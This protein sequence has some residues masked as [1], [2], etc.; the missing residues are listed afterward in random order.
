MTADDVLGTVEVPLEDLMTK[1]ETLNRSTPH[2]DRFTDVGGSPWPGSVRWS[3]GY[4]AKTGLEAAKPHDAEEVKK[5]VDKQAEEKLKEAQGRGQGEDD[6]GELR[7]QKAEDLKE[8][9]EEIIAGARPSTEWPSGVLSI[10]IE[11]ITGLEVDKIR[12]SGVRE[13]GEDEERDDLPSAYCTVIIDH[14]R[15]YKTRTKLK[16]GK[17]FVRPSICL[18]SFIS[19]RHATEAARSRVLIAVQRRHRAVHQRLATHHHHH[20]CARRPH[21]RV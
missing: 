15:V 1:S 2:E 19:V 20:R 17:P 16:S 21:A 7:R 8:R 5:K 9:T 14:Q 6:H 10:R 12:E 4:F 3:V 11:Q 13:G 18:P